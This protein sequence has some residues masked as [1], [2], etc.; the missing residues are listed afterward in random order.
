MKYFLA[1]LFSL[2]PLAKICAQSAA[3][4]VSSDGVTI[5]KSL[6]NPSNGASIE[7]FQAKEID[8][9]VNAQLLNYEKSMTIPGYRVRLFSKSGQNAETEANAVR[10]KCTTNFPGYTAYLDYN[11]PNYLVN[12]G[13]FRTKNEAIKAQQKLAGTFPSSFVVA[14]QIKVKK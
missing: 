8:R 12:V 13:D 6:K 5:L 10:R 9:V 1:F 4:V 3:P 7:V 11:T 14:A 2:F